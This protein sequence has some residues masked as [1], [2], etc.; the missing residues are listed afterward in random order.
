MWIQHYHGLGNHKQLELPYNLV[1]GSQRPRAVDT[2]NQGPAREVD[3]RKS[4]STTD[5]ILQPDAVPV[6]VTDAIT[7][8]CTA[9]GA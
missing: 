6:S 2:K 3:H 5:V 1:H 8:T 9:S 4:D 7:G